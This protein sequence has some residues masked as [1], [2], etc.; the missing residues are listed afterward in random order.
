MPVIWITVITLISLLHSIATHL[1]NG[2]QGL[3]RAR[4]SVRIERWS[5]EKS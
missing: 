3:K 5:P 4:S 1:E 2:L